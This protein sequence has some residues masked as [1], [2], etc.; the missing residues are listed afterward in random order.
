METL[1]IV[2][3]LFIIL[4]IASFRWG[5]GSTVE[6]RLTVPSGSDLLP[7]ILHKYKLQIAVIR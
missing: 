4:D 3:M 5:F 1:L 7:G 6:R 2:V